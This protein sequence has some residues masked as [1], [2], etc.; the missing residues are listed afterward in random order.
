MI[1]AADEA[2]CTKE[3]GDCE[4]P[5]ANFGGRHGDVEQI[6]G[7]EGRQAQQ[8]EQLPTLHLHRLVDCVPLPPL[9]LD[10]AG[11]AVPH[12]VP[13]H[14]ASPWNTSRCACKGRSTPLGLKGKSQAWSPRSLVCV[15]DCSL[16]IQ[17]RKPMYTTASGQTYTSK[18]FTGPL[19]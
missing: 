19:K 9:A 15:R 13:A 17:G 2:R 5:E 8:D 10:Q 6:V 16:C 4:I 14:L 12:E 18:D 1:K 11:H 7:H 3:G